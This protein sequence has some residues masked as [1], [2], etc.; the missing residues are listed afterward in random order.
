MSHPPFNVGEF[1][2]LYREVQNRKSVELVEIV[3]RPV[4]DISETASIRF[5]QSFATDVDANQL[6]KLPATLKKLL[7]ERS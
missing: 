6:H 4:Y 3:N 5:M 1:A 7:T 2:I